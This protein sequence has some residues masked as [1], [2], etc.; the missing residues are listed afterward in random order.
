MKAAKVQASLRIHAVSTE[1]PLL[2]HTSSES[3]GTSDR[4]PDPWPLWM[5]GHVQL[6]FVMTECSKT[7]IRLMPHKWQMKKDNTIIKALSHENKNICLLRNGCSDD[8]L[9]NNQGT[10]KWHD[11]YLIL[12]GKSVRWLNTKTSHDEKTDTERTKRVML[13][14]GDMNGSHLLVCKWKEKIDEKESKPRA[15]CVTATSKPYC[16]GTLMF[17]SIRN[18]WIISSKFFAILYNFSQDNIIGDV[19]FHICHNDNLVEFNQIKYSSIAKYCDFHLTENS[20]IFLYV[21]FTL[22]VVNLW[23]VTG[24]KYLPVSYK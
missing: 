1:P 3:R 15:I 6:K 13:L 19:T 11:I 14:C 8:A 21:N 10:H 5:A 17:D 18:P 7:H 20:N 24:T 9:Y 12:N 4:K 16:S 23:C 2:A 22:S